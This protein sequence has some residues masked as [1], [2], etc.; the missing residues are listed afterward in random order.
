MAASERD[1]CVWA[2]FMSA[3]THIFQ[4]GPNVVEKFPGARTDNGGK[5][6]A[7]RAGDRDRVLVAERMNIVDLKNR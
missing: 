1:P 4:F 7:A 5:S 2:L 6:L 3:H